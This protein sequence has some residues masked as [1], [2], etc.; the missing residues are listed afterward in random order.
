[1]IQR[2][3]RYFREASLNPNRG[4]FTFILHRVTG[5][6][7]VIYLF[8]HIWSLS[9]AFE[10]IAALRSAFELY[11]TPIFHI[12]EYL[13]LICVLIHGLNGLRLL[14]TDLLPITSKQKILWWFFFIVF[15]GIAAVSI[16]W[17]LPEL[18]FSITK[19]H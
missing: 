2:Y 4:M 11:N 5:V 9:H 3:L 1:M 8:I 17:F 15:I 12:G 16:L 6:F 18:P 10:G 13:L 7:L 14:L 19:A